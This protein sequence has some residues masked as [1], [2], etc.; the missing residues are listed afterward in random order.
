MWF[1]FHKTMWL[2][3]YLKFSKSLALIMLRAALLFY[4][5]QI[6]DCDLWFTNLLAFLSFINLL[7]VC[8]NLGCFWKIKP[9]HQLPSSFKILALNPS[10]PRDLCTCQNAIDN[11]FSLYLVWQLIPYT[12]NHLCE[13]LSRRFPVIFFFPSCLKSMSSG[14]R[15]LFPGKKMT[16]I[17][18]LIYALMIL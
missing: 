14:F 12:P 1:P 16:V 13:M 8:F 3:D 2:P 10:V 4:C 11:T 15:L 18:H 7:E 5:W 17:I 9:K 6:L